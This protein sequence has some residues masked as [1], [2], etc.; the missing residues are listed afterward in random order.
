MEA[1]CERVVASFAVSP[2]RDMNHDC[3]CACASAHRTLKSTCRPCDFATSTVAL[4]APRLI[5]RIGGLTVRVTINAAAARHA[6]RTKKPAL[7]GFLT[8]MECSPSLRTIG[9]QRHRILSGRGRVRQIDK[10]P[11]GSLLHSNAMPL[12]R[13]SA[14]A[15][16]SPRYQPPFQVRSWTN[17]ADT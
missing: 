11:A 13:L 17:I 6:M 4:R 1:P 2:S 14:K 9:K 7:L 10:H 5:G 16:A 12:F 3:R 15:S 8:Y